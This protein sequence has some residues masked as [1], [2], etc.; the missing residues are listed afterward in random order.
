MKLVVKGEESE[1]HLNEKIPISTN[2]V[3]RYKDTWGKKIA[4]MMRNRRI[5]RAFKHLFHSCLCFSMNQYSCWIGRQFN[6][7]RWFQLSVNV[8]IHR[9]KANLR[10]RPTDYYIA[11][12]R[13][14][15]HRVASVMSSSTFPNWSMALGHWAASI[16]ACDDSS[17][18][19]CQAS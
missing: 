11:P 13:L 6:S 12:L 10:T 5:R 15:T 1:C 16:D 17:N 4:Q 18:T 19:F 8:H 3:A 14:L 9:V 7:F 2:N